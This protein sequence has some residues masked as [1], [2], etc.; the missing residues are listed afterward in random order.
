MPTVAPIIININHMTPSLFERLDSVALK[1]QHTKLKQHAADLEA[2]LAQRE[3]A[4]V[5]LS[6]SSQSVTRRNDQLNEEQRLRLRQLEEDL[7]TQTSLC[8]S[9]QIH[10]GIII[11]LYYRI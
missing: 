7:G 5:Q 9:L 4:L 6:A 8:A 2:A 1:D 11:K 10:V 3:S